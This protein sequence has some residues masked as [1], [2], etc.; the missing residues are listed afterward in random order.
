MLA[1][2]AGM[3]FST[4]AVELLSGL[5][6][7]CST[8]PTEFPLA[9]ESEE[10]RGVVRGRLGKLKSSPELRGRYVELVSDV[11][12]ALATDWEREGRRCVNAAVAERR[13][14][15]AKEP[16]G[17]RSAAPSTR[18]SD[19][20]TELAGALE[21]GGEIAGLF[22]LAQ[23]TVSNHMKVLRDAGLVKNGTDVSRRQLFVQPRVIADLLEHLEGILSVPER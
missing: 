15:L 8:A 9:S 2:H 18:D 16:P 19:L 12:N 14:L 20:L 7:A 10:D 23:P 1:H 21:P 3:L 17:G 22:S 11:W 6:G 4:N 5:R 13:E